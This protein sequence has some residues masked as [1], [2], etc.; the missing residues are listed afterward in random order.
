[1]SK[2]LNKA[3]K[4]AHNK[5]LEI[6]KSKQVLTD[7]EMNQASELHTKAKAQGML[8]IPDRKV[9]NRARFVQIMQDNWSFMQSHQYLT[10]EQIVFLMNLVPHIAIGSNAI[11]D[12][13]KK[14]QPIGLNQS[15]IAAVLGTSKAKVS[16]VVK[17]LVEKGVLAKA[18]SGLEGNNVKSYVIFVNPHVLYSGNKDVVEDSLKIMFAKA[19]KMPVLKN[20][21]ERLF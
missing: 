4:K 11:V 3:S 13:P 14:K 21:P 7:E 6:E 16:R 10:S 19:M 5:D 15:E 9:R 2:A 18:E 20:L 1:M 17:S 12:A 8:L